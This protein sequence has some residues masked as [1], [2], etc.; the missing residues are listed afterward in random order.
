MEKFNKEYPN[1]LFTYQNTISESGNM[2]AYNHWLLIKGDDD[3]FNTWKA[4]NE[5]KWDSF[6]KWY[7]ANPIKLDDTNHFYRAQ[8]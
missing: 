1:V 2:E 6:V 8:Y 4:A 5:T 3:A 7:M